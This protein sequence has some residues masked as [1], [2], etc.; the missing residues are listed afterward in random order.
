MQTCFGQEKSWCV[1]VSSLISQQFMFIPIHT[2]RIAIMRGMCSN[3]SVSL[4]HL[5]FVSN[6][7]VPYGALLLP[8]VSF[9]RKTESN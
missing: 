6:A 7:H 1:L 5:S 2:W 9:S 8:Y 3:V 4:A